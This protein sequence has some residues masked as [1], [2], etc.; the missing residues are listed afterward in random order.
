MGLLL[1]GLS[2]VAVL[3]AAFG[4]V[5]YHQLRDPAAAPAHAIAADKASVDQSMPEVQP[6]DTGAADATDAEAKG[7]D[8]VAAQAPAGPFALDF[9]AFGDARTAGR[10]AAA[11]AARGVDAAPAARTDGAGRVWFHVMTGGF[12][13]RGAAEAA[14]AALADVARAAPRP[15]D[16][17]EA[18]P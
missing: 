5:L 9:G 14:A 1:V 7:D 16:V 12:A 2:T 17:A 15:V 10:M 18:T 3:A 11:L 8:V 6:V 13:S 4:A